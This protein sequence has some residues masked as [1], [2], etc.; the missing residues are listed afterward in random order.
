MYGVQV[1]GYDSLK[2]IIDY[3][4]KYSCEVVEQVS[5]ETK[6]SDIDFQ[7]TLK[8]TA[9]GLRIRKKRSERSLRRVSPWAR[10]LLMRLRELSVTGS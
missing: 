7:K 8:A 5:P 3:I 4:S 1:A 10:R 2:K 9:A 6:V